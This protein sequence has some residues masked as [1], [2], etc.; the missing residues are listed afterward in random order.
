MF[1]LKNIGRRGSQ[2][3][4][5]PTVNPS[6][7][8]PVSV[9]STT[10]KKQRKNSSAS[11]PAVNQREQEIKRTKIFNFSNLEQFYIK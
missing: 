8:Q 1:I 10:S 5:T 3:Q 2:K 6:R 11:Q 7:S 4:T 9:E